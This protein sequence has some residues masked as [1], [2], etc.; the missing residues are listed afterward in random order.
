MAT[1]VQGWRKKCFYIKDQKTSSSDLYNIAPFDADKD[2]T[3]LS[4]WDSPP[5]EAKTE[6]IKPLLAHIQSLKS[7]TGGALSG[8]QLM[9]FFL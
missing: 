5:T 9:T 2:L 7:A 1:S 6:D 4:S 3:K 8:M